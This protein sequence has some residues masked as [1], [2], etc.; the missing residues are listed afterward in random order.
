[1]PPQPGN[2][3]V[4]YTSASRALAGVLV[5]VSRA[6]LPYLFFRVVFAND[7]PI[8]PPILFV[9]VTVVSIVPALAAW[10]IARAGRA[11]VEVGADALTLRRSRLEIEFVE[12]W[13]IPLPG[14]GVS[15]RMRSG[16]RASYGIQLDDPT[17][18]IARAPTGGGASRDAA[19]RSQPIVAWARARGANGRR[20]WPAMVGKFGLFALPVAA[21]LFNAHQHIAY[22]GFWGQYY[23]EGLGPYLRTALVYYATI[24]V[25]LV[26]Y[27]SVLR[28]IG[29]AYALTSAHAA[30]AS[31]THARRWTE[32]FCTLAYYLGVPAMLALR[33]RP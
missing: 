25:Y 15:L 26:L 13:L 16:R 33:F 5:A 32:R 30:P 20:A 11:D 29:E 2:Q 23:Q 12:P 10:L 21:I 28:T 7:P 8:T 19:E 4:V 17:A 27:A 22:G 6:S 14:P 3:V 24:V 18:L 31:A 1:L 9:L